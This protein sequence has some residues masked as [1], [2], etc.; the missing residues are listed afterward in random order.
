MLRRALPLAGLAVST[1]LTRRSTAAVD[2]EIQRLYAG[3]ADIHEIPAAETAEIDASG[4][5]DAYGELTEKGVRAVLKLL[6][7]RPGDVFVDLGSGAGRMCFQV[8]LEWPE[9]ACSRGV[10]LSGSRHAAGLA[11][12]ARADAATARRVQLQQ[13]DII[14]TGAGDATIGYVASL[15][16]D[17]KFMARLGAR[18][19]AAPRLR[20]L[21][22]LEP[23]PPGSLT[24]FELDAA[25]HPRVEVTWGAAHV[26][27]YS[28]RTDEGPF[29]AEA[30]PCWAQQ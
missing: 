19:D 29:R 13:A 22:S 16:F 3:V 25:E 14:E 11:A 4:G 15:L 7:P 10:E 2:A 23:F 20:R 1:E 18:L 17:E 12:L 28:R 21:V 9:I 27:V 30:I 24:S 6:A 8:A 26:Y 5:H